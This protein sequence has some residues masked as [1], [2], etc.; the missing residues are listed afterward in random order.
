MQNTR[1][2][3]LIGPMGAGKTTVGRHLAKTLNVG[4]FDSDRELESTTGVNIPVIFDYE[5]EKGFR[6]REQSMID[7]L[8]Q[9]TNIVLATGGGAILQQK[10]RQNLKTRGFVVYLQCTVDCQVKRTYRDRHRPL[11]Q[12]DEPRKKLQELLEIREPYYL[13]CADHIVDTGKW[14]TR[15]VVKDIINAYRRGKNNFQ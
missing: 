5:G 4:F 3:F 13:D 7:R 8:T 10:N 15:F 14:P 12:T 11:L 6:K 1:N 2:I 9:L